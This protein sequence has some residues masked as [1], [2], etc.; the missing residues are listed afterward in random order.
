MRRPASDA[1]AARMRHYANEAGWA[2][3]GD[4]LFE[5]KVTVEHESFGEYDRG[6]A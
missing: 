2:S 3:L 6:V 5:A 4:A 1:V